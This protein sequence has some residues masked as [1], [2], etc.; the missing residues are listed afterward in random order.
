MLKNKIL[1][2]KFILKNIKILFKH[3]YTLQKS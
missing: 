2:I 3:T 1:N